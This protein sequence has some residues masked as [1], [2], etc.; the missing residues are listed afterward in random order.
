MAEKK[1]WVEIVLM[2]LV[3]AGV[4]ILGTHFITQQQ[5]KNAQ[6]KADS[7]RHKWLVS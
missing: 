4:G 5:E 6:A 3:V 1:N 2:P 7:D